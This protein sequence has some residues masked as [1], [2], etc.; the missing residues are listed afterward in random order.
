MDVLN[1][2]KKYS[3]EIC[4]GLGIGGF[5]TAMIFAV[6]STPKAEVYINTKKIELDVDELTPIET[7]KTV[8]SLYLPSFAMSIASAGLIISGNRVQAKRG[9]AVAAA[10]KLS[11]IAASEY[12]EAVI[13]AIGEK[14]EKN[15][16]GKIAQ[17]K[18]EKFDVPPWD[19]N[20][21]RPWCMD[22]SAKRIFKATY[23]EII[24]GVNKANLEL[25]RGDGYCSV[26]DLHEF[27]GLEGS[28]FGDIL[29]WTSENGLIEVDT[30]ETV[31][32]GNHE[33]CMVIKYHVYPGHNFDKYYN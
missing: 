20:D 25:T 13:D 3:P 16:R 33:P 22:W 28:D 27:W 8:W 31:M 6:K 7:V 12:Q 14:K 21:G 2:L 11:E 24:D 17:K 32:L 18:A 5:F 9:A 10:Y 26:S 4:T 29:G 15:I 30:S 19:P 1:T 23:D